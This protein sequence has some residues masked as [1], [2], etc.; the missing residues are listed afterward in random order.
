MGLIYAEIEI[1]RSD[2]LALVNEGYIQPDKVRKMKVQALVDSGAYMLCINE[3]IKDQLKL[4]KLDEIEAEM[5]DCRLQKT[6]I[7]GPV[8]IQF[9]TRS[10]SCRVVVLPGTCE[11]LLS[12]I[13]RED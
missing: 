2:D 13:P 6:E 1:I 12:S 11:V 3:N 7:L 4:K 8:E 5:A 10:T 9:E